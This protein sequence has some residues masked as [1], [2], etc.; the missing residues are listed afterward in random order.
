MKEKNLASKQEPGAEA[1]PPTPWLYA[2]EEQSEDGRWSW[3]DGEQCVFG[4]AQSA[5]DE[6]DSLNDAVEEW[7]GSPYRVVPLY[8]RAAAGES[9]ERTKVTA[10]MIQEVMV[11]SSTQQMA[12]ALNEMLAAS[13]ER[14]ALPYWQC[15]NDESHTL[16]FKSQDVTRP[17]GSRCKTCGVDAV[18]RP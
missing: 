2:I 14:S 13:Q 9:T 17:S 5:Q 11:L 6:V 12:N 18:Y 8:R 4:D 3:H 10:K 7:Q 1:A 16:E 15:P